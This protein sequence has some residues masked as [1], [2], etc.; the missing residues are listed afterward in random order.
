MGTQS[1]DVPNIA[2]TIAEIIQGD[3][4]IPFYQRNYNWGVTE[5]T[6][7]L[8]DLYESFNN[9]EENYF[10]G[11][12]V[13]FKRIGTQ[14]FLEVI[15]GQQRLTTIYLILYL[16]L[17][18]TE[19]LRPIQYDSRPEVVAFFKR[20]K[21]GKIHFKPNER[22][23]SEPNLI[24]FLAAKDTI[25]G[26]KLVGG[27]DDVDTLMSL[28]KK[29]EHHCFINFILHKV[30]LVEVLMPKDTDVASYF[31]IMNNRGRQ[32]QEHEIIK[33]QLMSKIK[34]P[35][36][37]SV[38]G[39]IWDACSEMNRPIHKFFSAEDRLIIFGE[40]YDQIFPN[41]IKNLTAEAC[42]INHSSILDILSNKKINLKKENTEE[43]EDELDEDITY[44][45]IIDFQNFLIHVLKLVYTQVDVPLSSDQLLKIY[46]TIPRK[47]LDTVD[48]M[49]FLE[50]L[51]FYRVIFDRFIIKS[52]AGSEN[53]D[54]FESEENNSRWILKKPVM[55]WKNTR[56]YTRYYR[57]LNFNNTFD[58]TGYQERL[59]KLLSMLQVT[60]RQRKNK[61]YLQF[62]L[63]LF[64][65]K[66]PSTI[67][68]ESAD[69]LFEIE[70]F[71]LDQFSKLPVMDHLSE[72]KLEDTCFDLNAIYAEGTSTPHFL[73][74]FIDY[75]LWVD[76]YCNGTKWGIDEKFD[77]TYR[78]SIEHHF[79]QAQSDM[80]RGS[81][82]EKKILLHSIGNL[83]LIS[84]SINSK[85]N[86]RSAWDKATD[87]RYSKGIL[88]PKRKIMYSI[89]KQPD[90]W[91]REQIVSHYQQIVSLLANREDILKNLY[92]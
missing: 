77:F 89:T 75:L 16:L 63:S 83:C 90:K 70:T 36:H 49:E 87:P 6:Q 43:H 40:N 80:L 33:A 28:H 24:N 19:N 8:Q 9:K 61:N 76:Q 34:N 38:F 65:P 30:V 4:I 25:L 22:E 48:P 10:I 18:H 3:F 50:K 68:I 82:E 59:V 67:N 27:V 66:K 88:T 58:N 53:E 81:D 12:L 85:L 7:L 14:D 69:F 64:D 17:N 46:K 1:L 35:K 84:K 72:K 13:V 39:K 26:A 23:L 45:A 5:I 73:F 47:V 2:K 71:V 60:Y 32:L 11:N 37:Q 54:Q 21:Q 86:D 78:N 31:E 41:K 55:Y 15:D 79:P 20:L 74:N 51:F 91:N 56:K 62:V 44:T 42:K 92:M 29:N 57:T 52:I